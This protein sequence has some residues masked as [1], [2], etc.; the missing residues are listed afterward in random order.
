MRDHWEALNPGSAFTGNRRGWPTYALPN[1]VRVIVG[2][3][4]R[5]VWG[6]AHFEAA[7]AATPCRPVPLAAY[8]HP[9][10]ESEGHPRILIRITK[11]QA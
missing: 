7:C 4:E 5:N 1:G 10:C 2:R 3:V 9:Y 11:E 8:A 6:A